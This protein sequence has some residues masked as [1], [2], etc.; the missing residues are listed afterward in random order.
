MHPFGFVM[1]SS[2]TIKDAVFGNACSGLAKFAM[3]CSV[4]SPSVLSLCVLM[5][6]FTCDRTV[7]AQ[8]EAIETGLTVKDI[9][10]EDVQLELAIAQPND[11]FER[12]EL[13]HLDL[14]ARG[15][16]AEAAE[17]KAQYEQQQNS[18]EGAQN[19]AAE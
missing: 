15:R 10:G 2:T 1:A 4:V 7:L 3:T 9:N 12:V 11:F 5:W 14:I 6:T 16:Q 19:A 8:E 13:R 18:K 17:F